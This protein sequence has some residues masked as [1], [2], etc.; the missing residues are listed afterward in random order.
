M[1]EFEL[2]T[3]DDYNGQLSDIIKITKACEKAGLDVKSMINAL[4]RTDKKEVLKQINE[5]SYKKTEAQ[6]ALEAK[7]A[8]EER[9]KDF[10]FEN[11]AS[12]SELRDM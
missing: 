1:S 11:R 7:I 4:R 12:L 3:N 2:K 6:K 8:Q 5:Y 9:A 10:G